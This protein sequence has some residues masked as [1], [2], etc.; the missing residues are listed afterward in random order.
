MTSDHRVV[1]SGGRV[2]W[3]RSRGAGGIGLARRVLSLAPDIRLTRK[4]V[5]HRRPD[6]ADLGSGVEA[7]GQVEV[8]Q[9]QVDWV[10]PGETEGEAGE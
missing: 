5:G 10:D 4:G 6:A 7:A 1:M 3:E 2:V 9:R 8:A